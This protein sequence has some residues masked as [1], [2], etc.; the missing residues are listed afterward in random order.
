MDS[1]RV[2]LIKFGKPTYTRCVL[3]KFFSF[4]SRIVK[5]PS[6]KY[7]T[8]MTDKGPRYL[9]GVT[10]LTYVPGYGNEDNYVKIDDL[11]QK[12]SL[13]L[14]F[15]SSMIVDFVWLFTKLPNNRQIILAKD[16][17]ENSES[18]GLSG[19]PNTNYL[20]VHAPKAES[21]FGCFH[22]K[23]MLLIFDNW[24][25]VVISSG[26][27]ISQD[28]ELCENVVFVQD[29]PSRDKSKEYN[30]LPE[31]A[32]TINDML[33]TMGLKTHII[34]RLPEYDYSKAKAVLIPS[35]PGIYKGMD[36]IK[37]FGH[38][39]ICKAVRELC[40]EREEV[41]QLEVQSSSIG[42][43]NKQFLNEFYRSAR[44]L[45]PISAQ[46]RPRPKKGEV[47]PLPPINIV[48]P[49]K[50]V[51]DESKYNNPAKVSI[52]STICLSEQAYNK[53][54]FPKE[55]L[56][57]CISKRNG[58]LMHSKFILAKYQED[59]NEVPT[60]PILGESQE[61]I[62]GWY[63]CGSHNFSESALGKITTS[64]ETKQLQIKINNWELGVFL[65][66]YKKKEDYN[67]SEDHDKRDWFCD[68][69]IP[70]PYVRPPPPYKSDEMPKLSI[71]IFKLV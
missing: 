52:A 29:F 43:L 63:Y 49:S 18:Q 39:R 68:H 67:P 41:V 42:S 21:K 12:S 46:S 40:G 65:P 2:F 51:V 57:N 61:N 71:N 37:K 59:L 11:I 15:L 62:G 38:G 19:I 47:V 32:Q 35:I 8:T 17:D 45:D 13:K 6:F 16:W 56:R 25:R 22:A 33:V 14:A 4:S 36:N 3:P 5:P 44:G 64:R 26:N 9:D 20:I 69:S 48:Y 55:I 58:L 23:L 60:D 34:P 50:K 24:M 66:I 7:I 30:G 70:V 10:K 53:D 27:L 31:F 54:T 1:I 28:W